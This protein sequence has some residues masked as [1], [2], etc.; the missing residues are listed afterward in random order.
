MRAVV[1]RVTEARVEV[2]GRVTGS[3]G[4]GVVVLV[5]VGQD[6]GPDDVRYV[7]AKVQ[8]L[9]IFD[10]ENLETR[11][12]VR[13]VSDID[14]G[15]LVVS[16]F[17]LYGDVRRGRRPSFERA[18]D[19]DRAR[20]LYQDLVRE[21]RAAGLDVATGE[22]KAMMQVHLVNDGPVTILLDSASAP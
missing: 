3:I 9:R 21:L 12:M 13:S 15:V 14:G 5:G 20:Q 6:D 19:T 4:R 8:N 7:A 16:Q 1:Q 2:G 18:A 11:S 10:V 17:T 22:F